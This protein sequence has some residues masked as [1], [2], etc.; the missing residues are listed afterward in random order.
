VSDIPSIIVTGASGFIGRHFLEAAR[1]HYRIYAVARR[2]QKEAGVPV[3]PQVTWIQVDIADWAALKGVMQGIKR[4]GGADYILHLA[5]YYDFTYRDHPEY[6]RS[7]V[8]GTRHMLELAKWLCV[9]RFLFAGSL[10]ACSFPPVGGTVN[11]LSP[12]DARFHYARSK[13]AGEEMVR[14]Y[15]TWF[16]ACVVRFAAVFSEYCEYAPLY[17][18]LDTWLSDRWNARILAGGGESAVTYV[19]VEELCRLLL[20]VFRESHRLPPFAVYCGSP[21]GCTT[22]RRLYEIGTRYHFGRVRPAIHLPAPLILAGLPLHNLLRRMSGRT[23]FE[24]LW[25]VRY[26]DRRLNVDA[27]FTHGV[28]DWQPRPRHHIERRLPFLI[29]KMK[30][31]PEE[32]RRRNEAAM[33]RVAVRPQLLI[34]QMLVRRR[35]VVVERVLERVTSNALGSRCPR[36][37]GLPPAQLR[38][39]VDLLVNM[40]IASIRT[41]DRGLLLGYAGDLAAERFGPGPGHTELVT[42]LQIIDGVLRFEIEMEPGLTE[43]EQETYDHVSFTVQLTCDELEEMA[44]RRQVIPAGTGRPHPPAVEVADSQELEEIIRQLETFYPAETE[45]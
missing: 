45:P 3:H 29:E 43:F 31:Q 1:E 26:I 27:S 12:P 21:D 38:Q 9:R 16:P 42:L 13:R 23:P 15:A 32:W 34:A 25:M 14:E 19:Q 39:Q 37:R 6:E 33:R 41:G 30:G 28:L 40:L 22:Q 17:S 10:A 2:S 4:S 7:N 5:G 18:F 24:R 36:L 20:T 35:D 8:Q 11:E 44:E